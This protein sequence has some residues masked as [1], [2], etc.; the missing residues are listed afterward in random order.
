MIS[1][2]VLYIF[3]L[4]DFH[5]R[6]LLA[7]IYRLRD[8]N[9]FENFDKKLLVYMFHQNVKQP[10][11][12]SAFKCTLISSNNPSFGF[13]LTNY[14][15]NPTLH[16]LPTNPQFIFFPISSWFHC[17]VTCCFGHVC[18]FISGTLILILM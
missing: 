6:S 7:S 2:S 18:S 1:L 15:M 17:S 16:R 3:S 12:W 4:Y 10:V 13:D 5:L 11:T 9:Q 14:I 8:F